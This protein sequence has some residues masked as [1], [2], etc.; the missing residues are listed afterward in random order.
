[1]CDHIRTRSQ[2]TTCKAVWCLQSESK[3]RVLTKKGPVYGLYGEE[4]NAAA[5]APTHCLATVYCVTRSV[6][7]GLCVTRRACVRS[8]EMALCVIESFYLRRFKTQNVHIRKH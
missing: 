3:S 2:T 5:L 4:A 7:L 6:L 1:M 8:P